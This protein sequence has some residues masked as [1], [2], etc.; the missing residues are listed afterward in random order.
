M[1]IREMI[2]K[3]LQTTLGEGS[4]AWVR[5]EGEEVEREEQM[6]NQED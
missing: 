3:H 1:G 4:V 2:S 5:S 6:F